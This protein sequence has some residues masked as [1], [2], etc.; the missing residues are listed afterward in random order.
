MAQGN[1]ETVHPTPH[2]DAGKVV[3]TPQDMVEVT[4]T[5]Q[6]VLET[7]DDYY[8][9]EFVDLKRDFLELEAARYETARDLEIIVENLGTGAKTADLDERSLFEDDAKIKIKYKPGSQEM[10]DHQLTVAMR[11]ISD[12]IERNRFKGT[13]YRRLAYPNRKEPRVNMIGTN[14]DEVRKAR[15]WAERV[16]LFQNKDDL[17]TLE[18][19]NPLEFKT[20]SKIVMSDPSPF[21]ASATT[22]LSETLIMK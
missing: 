6:Q 17:T 18:T 5:A 21:T 10:L 9:D 2:Q 8:D 16:R 11:T 12:A 22:P 4:W 1:D 19:K 15:F 20:I 14:I 3:A 13:S 7:I